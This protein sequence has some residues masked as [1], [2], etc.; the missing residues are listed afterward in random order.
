MCG[1]KSKCMRNSCLCKRAN[2]NCDEIC[3]TCGCNPNMCTNNTSIGNINDLARI[4]TKEVSVSARRKEREILRFNNNIDLY[5]QNRVRHIEDMEVDHIIENQIVGHA[6]AE[7]FSERPNQS[8]MPYIPVLRGALNLETFENYNVT[9]QEING[10]KG[11]VIGH[12][13]K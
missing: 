12:Y 9:L 2:R 13:L 4:I 3:D 10:S 5:T 7:T 6:V 8:F 1:P 11:F